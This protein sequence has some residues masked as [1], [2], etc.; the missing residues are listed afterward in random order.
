MDGDEYTKLL[1][2]KSY[3]EYESFENPVGT[4]YVE[5]SQGNF[6]YTQTDAEIE[7]E[8]LPVKIDRTYNS[9]ASTVSSLGLGWNH[10]YDIELLNIN[11]ADKLIDRKALRDET[12]TIFLFE[13]LQDGTYASSMG[14]Y[15]TLKAEEKK[16]TVEIPAKNG[17]SKISKEIVSSYTMLTKDNLE[18][19][20]NSGGQLIYVKE[21]NGSFLLLTHDGKTGRLLTAVTN[22]NLMVT[23]TYEIDAKEKADKIVEQAIE[24]LEQNGKTSKGPMPVENKVVDMTQVANN[25]VTNTGVSVEDAVNNLLLVRKISLPDGSDLQYEYDEQNHLN[26]VVRSDGKTNGE[27]VS[28]LYEY[29]GQGNLSVIKDANEIPYTVVYQGKR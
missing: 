9:Q 3:W 24:D 27:S 12:G 21:P 23:F 17:N 26:K 19:R 14:R 16:E 18:Y 25:N 15:I 2:Y 29:N 4:G 6:V 10:S 13:K 22:Q 28:Y 7:N 5:K 1:G 11:E 8:K 20:F